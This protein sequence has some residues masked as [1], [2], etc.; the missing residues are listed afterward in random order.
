MCFEDIVSYAAVTVVL[1][2]TKSVS[3]KRGL[4]SQTDL[5]LSSH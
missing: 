2:R 5:S 1:M 3:Y 4:C